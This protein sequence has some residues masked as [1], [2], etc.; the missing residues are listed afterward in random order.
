MIDLSINELFQSAPET[1]SS[2]SY[3]R[4]FLWLRLGLHDLDKAGSKLKKNMH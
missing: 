4:K 3:V 1:V 2:G